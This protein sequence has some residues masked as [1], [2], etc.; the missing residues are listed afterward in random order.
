VT[1]AALRAFA[2]NALPPAMVPAAFVVLDRLPRNPAGKVDR[3]ALPTPGATA[4]DR[5][6]FVA[7][8][9]ATEM[10]VAKIWGEVLRQERVGAED[11]FFDLGGNS[12]GAMRIVAR[13]QEAGIGVP[14]HA[15]FERGTVSRIAALADE[16]RSTAAGEVGIKRASRAQFR[17]QK[18]T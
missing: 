10:A 15:I 9:T 14:L 8:G 11:S 7:P 5:A 18:S 4:F 12:L 3:P 17:S 13:M 2:R 16:L 1:T 6:E